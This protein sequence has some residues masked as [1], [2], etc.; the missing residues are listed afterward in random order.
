MLIW[1]TNVVLTAVAWAA[2]ARIVTEYIPG[3]GCGTVNAI[4][5]LKRDPSDQELT[6]GCIYVMKEISSF[7]SKQGKIIAITAHKIFSY[8]FYNY[9][10]QNSCYS[11]KD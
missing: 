8:K 1:H 5:M 7:E 2:H 4:R 9:F 3:S 10:S 11:A 6:N